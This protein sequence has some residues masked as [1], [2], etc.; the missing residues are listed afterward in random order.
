M[1]SVSAQLKELR[2]QVERLQVEVAGQ[3]SINSLVVWEEQNKASVNQTDATLA[4]SFTGLVIHL[5]PDLS[6]PVGTIEDEQSVGLSEN[7][8]RRL[9]QDIE[10]SL[11]QSTGGDVAGTGRKP[12]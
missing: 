7:D 3:L 1:P 2:Q 8:F 10:R 6:P 11:D 12:H 4:D 9:K 5:T